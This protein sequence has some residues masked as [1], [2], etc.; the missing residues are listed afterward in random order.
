MIGG[1]TLVVAAL[2]GGAIAIVLLGWYRAGVREVDGQ[3][4]SS[5]AAVER[6][7]QDREAALAAALTARLEELRT[8]ESARPYLHYQNLFHDPS[9]G[10]EGLS[11]TPSPLATGPADPLVALHFQIDE[12]GAVSSPSVNDELPEAVQA[13]DPDRAALAAVATARAS[14]EQVAA[15]GAVRVAVEPTTQVA[16]VTPRRPSK[17]GGNAPVVPEPVTQTIELPPEAYLQNQNA[18]QIFAQTRNM[19]QQVLPPQQQ[20]RVEIP[21]GQPGLDQQQ[22]QLV[23]PGL[24]QQEQLVTPPQAPVASTPTPRRPRR[25]PT[26][27]PPAPAPVVIT[28]APLVWT[29]ATVDGAP[30]LVAVRQVVTP[31]GARTQGLTVTEAAVK[32]WLEERDAQDVIVAPAGGAALGV[33]ASPWTLHVDASAAAAYARSSGAMLRDG[34]LIKFVP[35]AVLAV[36]CGLLVVGVTARGEKLAQ[37]RA[38]FAAAAAHELRT[39]LA[40]IQLYGDMLAGELGDPAKHK[41]Y[42]HRIAVEASRLGRV[43]ANVMG[44]SQLER[45]ALAVRTERTDVVAVVTDAIERA[46]P[47]LERAG[48]TV[49]LVGDAPLSAQLDRDAVA[50]ILGNLLDNAEKYSRGA[51]DRTITVAVALAASGTHVEI[52]VR[53]RGPGLPAALRRGRFRA[54]RRA[55]GDDA[56]PGLGLGLALSQAL[57]VAMTGELTARAVSPGAELVLRLPT[58]ST[59]R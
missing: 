17:G 9:G 18:N 57:A 31:D 19:Q 38:R 39:P 2:I 54:F 36:L 49:E 28:V 53:D 55:A 13:K 10:S 3:I 45:G 20:Q 41:D 22:Q 50:R 35:V 12:R 46:R 44:V 33:T 29:T 56:P 34:F 26:P 42:A 32:A 1:R 16:V 30:T 59:P 37:E 47:G 7:A 25:A 43:V 24:D 52:A 8:T 51:D 23:E 6:E 14:L 4:A 40:G 27:T 5:V 11:V 21:I 58:A 48:A 15:R